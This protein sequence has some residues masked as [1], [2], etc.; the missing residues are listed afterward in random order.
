M[1][2]VS[3]D[4]PP[5]FSIAA[6]RLRIA[7]RVTPKAAR[8]RISGL[9]TD[10]AGGTALKVAVTAAPE[11]GKANAAVIKLLAK[12]WRLAKSD[13]AIVQGAAA[14]RKVIEIAGEADRVLPKLTAWIKKET[15][16][17]HG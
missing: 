11:G 3:S 6:N 9:A 4:V 15:G 13:L 16:D 2:A 8:N 12:E 10:A 14:R 5:P 17:H 7:V 1:A